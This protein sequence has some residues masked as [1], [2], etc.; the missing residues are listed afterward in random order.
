MQSPIT[1]CDHVCQTA[2]DMSRDSGVKVYVAQTRS[3]FHIYFRMPT[4]GVLVAA[5]DKGESV[6]AN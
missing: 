4:E 6:K 2:R 5:F 1:Q 3:A